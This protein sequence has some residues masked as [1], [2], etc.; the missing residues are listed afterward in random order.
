M[1]PITKDDPLHTGKSL[2][3]KELPVFYRV[4]CTGMRPM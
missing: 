1:N 2:N 3:S 4:R